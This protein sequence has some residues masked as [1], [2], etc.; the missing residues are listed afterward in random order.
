MERKECVDIGCLI[1]N[2]RKWLGDGQSIQQAAPSVSSMDSDSHDLCTLDA[3]RKDGQR[4]LL[5][6]NMR[7][8]HCWVGI[9]R[10][11]VPLSTCLLRSD[12]PWKMR[13]RSVQGHTWLETDDRGKIRQMVMLC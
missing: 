6:A 5:D 13:P 11:W 10:L 1:E 4:V 12:T 3:A 8:L 7:L 9:F 2:C